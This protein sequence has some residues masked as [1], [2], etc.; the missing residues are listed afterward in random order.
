M[1]AES[2]RLF[3][4]I[5]ARDRRFLALAASAVV[6]GTPAAVVLG[7][8]SSGADPNCVTTIRA[9]F[10]GGQTYTYCG[11]KG[12]AFCHSSASADEGVAAKCER[13]LATRLDP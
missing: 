7:G 3:H 8:T 2:K 13:L 9:G 12:V 6:I 11:A 4:R 10:M 5:G 1:P